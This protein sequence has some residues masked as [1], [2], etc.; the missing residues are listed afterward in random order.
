MRSID[1]DLN[2]GR[3]TPAQPTVHTPAH[4]TVHTEEERLCGRGAGIM[5]VSQGKAVSSEQGREGQV[6]VGLGCAGTV[7]RGAPVSPGPTATLISPIQSFRTHQ[8]NSVTTED[9]N[10][11]NDT[12]E[13]PR[14]ARLPPSS[15][16]LLMC[17][18]TQ[19]ADLQGPLRPPLKNS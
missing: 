3:H 9:V 16:P 13:E 7:T 6:G 4:P 11:P 17:G 18:L 2:L 12:D 10:R 15:L 14:G 19:G 1:E 5:P 8:T